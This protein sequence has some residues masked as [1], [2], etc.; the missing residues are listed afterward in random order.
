M[1]PKW[2]QSRKKLTRLCQKI[3]V[4]NKENLTETDEI[5]VWNKN[6]CEKFWFKL[7]ESFDYL[8]YYKKLSF[9]TVIVFK[10][11]KII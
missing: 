7:N 2:Q 8:S 4:K 1:W 3:G 5:A 6:E 11:S 9:F 10:N